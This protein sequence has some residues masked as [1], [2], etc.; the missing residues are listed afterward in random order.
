MSTLV[1]R[2][3]ILGSF[4]VLSIAAS[5]LGDAVPYQG[6]LALFATNGDRYAI[7]EHDWSSAKLQ[8]LSRDSSN[9]DWIL[10]AKNDFSFVQ[11]NRIGGDILFRRPSPALTKL[12]IDFDHKL[13]VGLSTIMVSNPY[14]LI[15]WNTHGEIVHREHISNLVAKLGSGG[16]QKLYRIF[17]EAKKTLERHMFVYN[18]VLYCDFNIDGMPKRIGKDAWN[19]LFER[20]VWHPYSDDFLESVSNSILWFDEANPGVKVIPNGAS[21]ILNIRSPKGRIMTI[22]VGRS[23]EGK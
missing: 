10:S 18:G 22:P 14:Q 1:L 12:Y 16:D 4:V 19:Y 11:L 7:H 21:Y 15:I 20:R 9:G 3:G 2:T 13:V 8:K 23:G 5:S 6:K 17:P